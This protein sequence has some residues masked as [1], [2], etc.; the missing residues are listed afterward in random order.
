MNNNEILLSILIAHKTIIVLLYNV[1][2]QS[3]I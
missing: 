2:N 1:L 3:K